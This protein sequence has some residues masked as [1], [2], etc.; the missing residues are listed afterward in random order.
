MRVLFVGRET[1]GYK[2]VKEPLYPKYETLEEPKEVPFDPD[3]LIPLYSRRR[4]TW[5]LVKCFGEAPFYR[6]MD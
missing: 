1:T 3:G 4:I 2:E 6:E 5:E